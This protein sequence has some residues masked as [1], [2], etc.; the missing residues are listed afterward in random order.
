[1]TSPAHPGRMLF[2]TI[3]AAGLERSKALFAKLG[4]SDNPMLADDAA[5][6]MLLD[7]HAF[8]MLLSRE[9][10]AEFAKL[11]IAAEAFAAAIQA[12]EAPA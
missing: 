7:E 10:F 1:M 4:F 2:V 6:W 12:A 11:P 9:K 8:V 3:P 5:A